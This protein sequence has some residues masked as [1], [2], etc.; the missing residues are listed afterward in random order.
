MAQQPSRVSKFGATWFEVVADRQQLSRHSVSA[1]FETGLEGEVAY[2]RGDGAQ[3]DENAGR[4][5]VA[6]HEA[7]VFFSRRSSRWMNKRVRNVLLAGR[8]TPPVVNIPPTE[9]SRRKS[10][11]PWSASR[12]IS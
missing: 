9:I 5:R 8:P 10:S 6:D 7:A 4:H 1:D 11:G 2:G 12:S 3:A